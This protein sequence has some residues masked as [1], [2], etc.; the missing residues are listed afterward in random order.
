MK[1]NCHYFKVKC[2]KCGKLGHLSFVCEKDE[3]QEMGNC[4]YNL[5]TGQTTDECAGESM[6]GQ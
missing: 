1:E 4:T 5:D 6:E 3:K 2:F